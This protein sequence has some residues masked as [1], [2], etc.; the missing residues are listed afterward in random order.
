MARKEPVAKKRTEQEQPAAVAQAAPATSTRPVHA[1]DPD[2]STDKT[3]RRLDAG[4][5]RRTVY[6]TTYGA[7]RTQK[8]NEYKTKATGYKGSYV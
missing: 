4:R 5:R 7:V 8:G 3:A 6:A 1:F 2:L